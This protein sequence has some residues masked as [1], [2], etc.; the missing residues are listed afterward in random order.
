MSVGNEM[1]PL[2]KVLGTYMVSGTYTFRMST[3]TPWYLYISSGRHI[4][5]GRICF[6]RIC[7]PDEK[8]DRNQLFLRVLTWV[9]Q[10]GRQKKRGKYKT[11]PERRPEKESST[12]IHPK[13]HT[14]PHIHIQI[15]RPF[16][17]SRVIH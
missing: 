17:Y 14:H 6:G 12:H 15:I 3:R 1:L 5:F 4:R 16:P 9:C 8:L 13:T 10:V 2:T 11:S 7:L